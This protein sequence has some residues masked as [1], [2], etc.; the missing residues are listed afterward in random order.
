MLNSEF[1]SD[2][3]VNLI[4]RS[5]VIALMKEVSGYSLP[6]FKFIE[7]FEKRSVLDVAF[8]CVILLCINFGCCERMVAMAPRLT[9]LTNSL[10]VLTRVH[11]FIIDI[12]G[13]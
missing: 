10:F 1:Y 4:F 11:V 3:D 13:Q 7:M 6:L 8:S 2:F 9:Q 5:E 12:T